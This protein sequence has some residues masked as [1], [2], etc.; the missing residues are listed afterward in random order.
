MRIINHWYD[1]KTVGKTQSQRSMLMIMGWMIWWNDRS[2]NG[3][4]DIGIYDHRSMRNQI[5]MD[6]RKGYFF[7]ICHGQTTTVDGS[8]DDDAACGMKLICSL[9]N[10][11]MFLI[12][13][14]FS[15]RKLKHSD[16]WRGS[17]TGH[18]QHKTIE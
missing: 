15:I 2:T 12:L 6:G 18:L 13:F 1:D 16:G 14:F 7:H 3:R 5:E 4:R 8:G 9:K 10:E 11:N 17:T